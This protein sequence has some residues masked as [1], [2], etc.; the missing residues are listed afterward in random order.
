MLT[1]AR[2]GS[3][4]EEAFFTKIVE[5]DRLRIATRRQES[6]EMA[7][8]NGEYQDIEFKRASKS[9]GGVAVKTIMVR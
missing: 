8:Y 4:I 6:E 2:P 3:K 1:V 5:L 9:L 7:R